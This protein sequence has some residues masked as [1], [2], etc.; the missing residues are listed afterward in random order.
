[1]MKQIMFVSKEGRGICSPRPEVWMWYN[2]GMANFKPPYKIRMAGLGDSQA[3]AVILRE[4]GWFDVMASESFE[5]SEKR[6]RNLLSQ[7]LSDKS[8]SIYV[9]AD[10]ENIPAG[11]ISAHWLP[12]LFLSGPEG[13]VSELFVSASAR[14]GGIGAALL[15][16]VRNEAKLRGCSRLSLLN[17]RQRESYHRKFYEKQGWEERPGMANFIYPFL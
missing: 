15:D 6:V 13:Y 7:G 3:L 17:G 12:H 4:T 2:G 1:M 14:G 8:H 11:Y 10:Q 16:A 5:E 9:A